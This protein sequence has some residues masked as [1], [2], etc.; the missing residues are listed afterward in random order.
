MPPYQ[1]EDGVAFLNWSNQT[2][3]I[4]GRVSLENGFW[5][6]GRKK[7]QDMLDERNVGKYMVLLGNEAHLTEKWC[8]L[9]IRVET[10]ED[11]LKA[12]EV[13]DLLA[14]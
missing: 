3:A 2:Y 11:A 13:L 12:Q 9:L 1:P 8:E 5:Q 7:V 4:R 10:R 6:E 14:A